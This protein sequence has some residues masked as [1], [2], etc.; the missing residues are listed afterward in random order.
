M[1]LDLRSF[2]QEYNKEGL[3]R[4]SI[5]GNPFV[6]FEQWLQEAIDTQ[7]SEPTAMIVGTVSPQGHP[8]TRTVLLKELRDESFVFYTNYDSRKGQ[9]LQH[10]PAISLSFVWHELERQ[11]HVEGIATKLPSSIS[12]EYFH[13][14]P[15]N[16]QIGARASLQS[17]PI[18]NRK[19][20]MDRFEHE[21]NQWEGKEIPRP[22]YWGGFRVEP[23]RIEFWQGR[24]SRLHDRFLYEWQ[25]DKKWN[26]HRLSP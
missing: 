17:T 5:P 22:A 24:P 11:I 15:I 10:N 14:R 25:A 21:L 19:E 6:L 12:D 13:S 4:E 1:D 9:H 20:L 3:S 2:R 26:I 23:H 18:A 8:A 16:S 7:A